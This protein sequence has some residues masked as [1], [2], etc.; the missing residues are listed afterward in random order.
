M[1]SYLSGVIAG[2]TRPL[3]PADVA[4]LILKNATHN[5]NQSKFCLV[6]STQRHDSILTLLEQLLIEKGLPVTVNRAYPDLQG[7]SENSRPDILTSTCNRRVILD[8]VVACNTPHSLEA[9]YCRKV[10]KYLSP[11]TDVLSLVLGVLGS[12]LPSND[13][14][15]ARFRIGARR[16]DVF[17]QLTRK[18]AISGPIEM[19]FVH[20]RVIRLDSGQDVEVVT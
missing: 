14:I 16:R 6:L 5:T 4:K 11:N 18:A 12:W 1:T 7:P 15:C 10:E 17:R 8:V 20:L 9:A 3:T 19:V 13:D 2:L